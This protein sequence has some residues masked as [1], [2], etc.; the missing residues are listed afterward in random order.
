MK[1]KSVGTPN[2]LP[3]FLVRHPGESPPRF[4]RARVGVYGIKAPTELL[5]LE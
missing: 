3:F 2:H 5:R 4:H 1:I